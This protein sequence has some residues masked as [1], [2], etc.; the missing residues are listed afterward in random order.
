MDSPQHTHP[1]LILPSVLLR[2]QNPEE[3]EEEMNK[4]ENKKRWDKEIKEKMNFFLCLYIFFSFF[5]FWVSTFGV[6][7]TV[8]FEKKCKFLSG[9]NDLSINFFVRLFDV[10]VLVRT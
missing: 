4:I 5:L 2:G 8:L 10:T 3:K 1:G 7:R 9:L 6:S